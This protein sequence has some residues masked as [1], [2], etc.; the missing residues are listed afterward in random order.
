[1]TDYS[2]FQSDRT[3]YARQHF[4]YGLERCGE[5]TREQVQLIM[6]HGFAYEALDKAERTPENDEE[7]QFVLFC[8][9]DKEAETKH[10]RVWKRFRAATSKPIVYVSM[11]GTRN[12]PQ[13][14]MSEESVDSDF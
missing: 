6:K 8:R 11:E 5:F 1:M 3:F 14:D 12:K 10:E 13:I 4:P 2:S 9:G 7:K